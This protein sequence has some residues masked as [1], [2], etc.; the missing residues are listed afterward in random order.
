MAKMTIDPEDVHIYVKMK[1]A[2]SKKSVEEY[3]KL[4][5]V[6]QQHLYAYLRGSRLPSKPV[7][8]KLGLRI[9][10]EIT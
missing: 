4:L 6:P 5:G 1:L 10:Y 9:V 3:A 2:E 8:A 7:L